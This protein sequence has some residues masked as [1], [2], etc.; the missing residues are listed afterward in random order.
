MKLNIRVITLNLCN[1]NPDK[2]TNLINKWITIFKNINAD[3]IFLQEIKGYNIEK[4]TKKL[5][6]ELLDI[7]KDHTC[8]LVN[9][10]KLTILDNKHITL[11]QVIPETNKNINLKTNK[12]IIYKYKPIFIGNLHLHDIPSIS[13]HINNVIYKS[14]EIIPLDYSLDKLLKMCKKNR[15]PHV[16]KELKLVKK[17]EIAIIAGDFNE[18]SHLDLHIKVPVSKEFEKKGFIDSY[19]YINKD[20]GYTWPSKTFYKNEPNQRIDIIY[21]KGIK[22]INSK[23]YYTDKWLSDHKMVITDLI[24]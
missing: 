19:R 5:N 22:I 24:I 13:H 7:S 20:K 8:V 18:P 21:I 14:S 3:I 2:K 23:T 11:K 17:N 12:N 15:I 6:M 9:P 10:Y 16:I 1:E 4:M